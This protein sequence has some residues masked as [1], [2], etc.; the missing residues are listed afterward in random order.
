MSAAVASEATGARTFTGS[1]SQGL[2]LMHE[3]IYVAS[4]M[5]LP[6]V[7]VNVSRALSAPITLWPDHND[8]L[9]QRDSGWLTVFCE[10]N[11]EVLD[12]VIMM[13]R[14]CEDPRV[15]LPAFVNMEGF[16]LSYTREPVT[17]PEQGLVDKFLP[18]Y[19]PKIF[20]DPKK[21]MAEGI[22]V[23]SEYTYFREQVH[24]AQKNAL[25]VVEEIQQEWGRM[26]GRKYDIIEPFMMEDA[27]AAFVVM[28]SST[29]IA[30]SA[31]SRMRKAGKRIGLLRIRLF[32]PFPAEELVRLMNGI[33]AVGVL[34][35][36]L[37]PGSGGILFSEV[38]STIYGSGVPVSD[39]IFSLGGKPVSS[40]EFEKFGDFVLDSA[41][42]KKTDVFFQD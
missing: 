21:P 33:K 34:D 17:I 23:M 5:R 18:S 22:G 2:M 29:T 24:L 4:G 36:N 10:T 8:I 41:K 16:Y 30:R 20:L 3:I 40:E 31:V 7:M 15:M 11:Q 28:G 19:E 42:T 32:R 39:F 35:Q 27:E 26:F 6:I 38:K 13:Y 9:D 25:E 1:S 37:A 14:V 12:T